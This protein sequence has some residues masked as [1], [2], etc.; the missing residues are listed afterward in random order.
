MP[1][2]HDEALTDEIPALTKAGKLTSSAAKTVKYWVE[3][4]EGGPDIEAWP[5]DDEFEDVEDR[6]EENQKDLVVALA[7]YW[8][9]KRDATRLEKM[10]QIGGQDIVTVSTNAEVMPQGKEHVSCDFKTTRGVVPIANLIHK[11]KKSRKYERITVMLDYFWMENSYY[12]HS[13]GMDWFR[14]A[15]LLLNAGAD[16][17]ILPWDKGHSQVG[18]PHTH[19][20][21]VHA[22]THNT[23]PRDPAP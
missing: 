16:E 15:E 12:P 18:H 9:N 22:H 8:T 4:W 1:F 17:V 19:T 5:S 23:H 21:I 7:M 20:P 10:Q 11:K 6:K 14:K 13:Y 3:R 2:V